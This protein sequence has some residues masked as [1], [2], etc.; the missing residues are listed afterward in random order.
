MWDQL[1]LQAQWASAQ[2]DHRVN[3]ALL[4]LQ[5]FQGKTDKWDQVEP[6]AKREHQVIVT[7][8]HKSSPELAD[9]ELQE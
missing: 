7:V 4:V 5:V 3:Q 9:L 6:K 1:D 8:Y 2:R